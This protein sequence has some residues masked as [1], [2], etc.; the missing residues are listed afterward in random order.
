M[1]IGAGA[2]NLY[3]GQLLYPQNWLL[4]T[5][6]ALVGIGAAVIWVAQ[7]TNIWQIYIEQIKHFGRIS[8]Q[9]LDCEL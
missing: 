2:Y 4:Y 5:S 8:G 7:V 9:L 3:V 6:S 1:M